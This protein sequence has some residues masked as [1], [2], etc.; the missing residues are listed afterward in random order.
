M[1]PPL[2]QPDV[3]HRVHIR[4][5]TVS[6]VLSPG[7]SA[8][9]VFDTSCVLSDLVE[10]MWDWDVAS[11][12][13]ARALSFRCT[14]SRGLN[15]LVHYRTP[16]HTTWKFGSLSRQG[17][18]HNFATMLQNG[19]VISVPQGPLG[20]LV[21]RLRPEA[22]T[23][24]VGDRLRYFLNAGI[25]LDDLF[26]ATG[27]SLL[28]EKLAEA[29]TSAERFFHMQAF[30]LSNRRSRHAESVVSRAAALLRRDPRLRVGQLAARLAVSE[31]HLSRD[32]SAMFGMGPKQ[33]AR[34]ARI[35]R[36]L[37]ARAQG[38]TWADIAY[39]TGFTDQAHM[40]NDFTAIVGVSPTELGRPPATH[41][42]S[43]IASGAT[44][45]GVRRPRTIA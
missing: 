29:T 25:G 14:P 44:A 21:V 33:F 43:R 45:F 26:G 23:R 30:L 32:F 41:I 42:G 10:E 28:G 2:D 4:N 16:M 39:A 19:V 34:L 1:L 17:Q 27:V 11:P 12:H 18:R 22:A 13:Q 15:L 38:A 35:E 8:E 36:V 40:I 20:M 6:S 9:P 3:K 24:L 37:A 5:C 7:E 31:R